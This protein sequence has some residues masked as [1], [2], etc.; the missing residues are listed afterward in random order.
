MGPSDKFEDD[1]EVFLAFQAFQAFLAFQALGLHLLPCRTL[2]QASVR[3]TSHCC[4]HSELFIQVNM[5]TIEKRN[6]SK[7]HHRQSE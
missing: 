3:C 4:H 5:H 2:H 6:E 1:L 7:N